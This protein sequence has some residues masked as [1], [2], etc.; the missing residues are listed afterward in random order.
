MERAEG[1]RIFYSIAIPLVGKRGGG[2]TRAV[3]PQA[4]VVAFR[5]FDVSLASSILNRS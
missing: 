1:R 4:K 5:D 3:W 2:Q